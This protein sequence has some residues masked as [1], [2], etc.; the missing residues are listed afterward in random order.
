LNEIAIKTRFL[1]RDAPI[2]PFIFIYALSFGLFGA[3]IPL[4]ILAANMS[5]IFG[6]KVTGSAF[7]ERIKQ[8]KS[9]DY[10][11]NLFESFLKIQLD[12]AFIN[13]FSNIFP[14]FKGVILEDSTIIELNKKV[15]K[16]FK[17]TGGVGCKSA[18]KLNWVFNICCYTAVAVDLCQGKVPDQKIARKS[19]KHLKKRMLIIR[20]LGYF[21]FASL[22]E[23]ASKGA[24][25]LSRVR[26]GTL[27]FLN[28]DDKDPVDVNKLFKKITFGGKSAVIPV[29]LGQDRLPNNLVVK[30]IPKWA[31]N[32]RMKKQ[33]KK[34]GGAPSEDF[35]VWAKYSIFITNI[36]NEL[37]GN[38]EFNNEPDISKIIIEIYKIRWQIELLFKKF[39]TKVKLDVINSKDKNQ[40]LCLIYGKLISIIMSMMVLSYATSHCFNSR[41]ISSWKVVTWLIAKDRLANAILEGTLCSLYSNLFKHFKFLC[42]DKRKRKT[43]QEQMRD[44]L[45]KEMRAA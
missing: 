16:K 12:L 36:P 8:K 42:K 22:K 24:Y 7:C 19:I 20:D 5:S 44:V 30:K 25:Y 27:I 17:G 3:S 1:V 6:I 2:T 4:D 45:G 18:I 10:M 21:T 43:A 13:D 15:R 37:W 38:N 31:F 26:Q 40:V 34:K 23:I 32:Q 28:E 41:E 39:K 33:K 11:K 29:Y 35:I 9:V 14:M